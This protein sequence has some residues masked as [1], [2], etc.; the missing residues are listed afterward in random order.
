MN[1]EV[2]TPEDIRPVMGVC[3]PRHNFVLKYFDRYFDRRVTADAGEITDKTF[4]V[5]IVGENDADNEEAARFKEICRKENIPVVTL[6]VGA[7]LGT[8]M[9]DPLMKIARHVAR[10]TMFLIK[11]NAARMSVIHAVDLP[12]VAKVVAD[13]GIPTEKEYAV[14]APPVAVSDL[15]VALAVRIKNK[16]VGVLKY[17]WARLLYGAAFFDSMTNDS[18][19][20][21]TDF[22]TAHPEFVFTNPVE[23]LKTH[24]YDDE[25]L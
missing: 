14:S 10:G 7:V 19:I 6:C 21:T 18:V 5:V 25:S 12:A 17:R 9:G 13:E 11:D 22:T 15:V 16:S 23:Y 4:A 1:L 20:D 3:A 8:G 24:I 2:S